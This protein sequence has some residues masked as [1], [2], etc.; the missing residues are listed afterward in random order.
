VLRRA[1]SSSIV[2]AILCVVALA[3]IAAAPAQGAEPRGTWGVGVF[4]NDGALDLRADFRELV[5]AGATP[6]EATDRL[7]AENELSRPPD[8]YEGLDW[9]G[10]AVTQWRLGRVVDHVRDTA[11]RVIERELARPL[12]RGPDRRRRA[13]VLMRTREQLTS[14]APAPRPVRLAPVAES[15]FRP[16]DMLRYTMASGRQVAF[17]AMYETRYQGYATLT[18]DTVFRLHAIGDP[19]LPPLEVLA[20]QASLVSGSPGWRRPLQI[21]FDLPQNATGPAW[22]VIGNVPFPD[23]D[24]GRTGDFRFLGIEQGRLPRV[25]ELQLEDWLSQARRPTP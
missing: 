20:Q 13:A 1:T 22:T 2:V 24:D 19:E 21:H 14:P 11:L 10:L 12:F 5:A 23:P 7:I 8:R 18:V 3:A 15:P 17:W 6:D 16:G 25:A 9:L 4:D